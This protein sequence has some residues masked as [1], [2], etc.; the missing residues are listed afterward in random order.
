MFTGRRMDKS[1]TI[2]TCKMEH[3]SA[4]KRKEIVTH[5]LWMNLED[6]MLN[7]ISQSEKGKHYIIPLMWDQ[8]K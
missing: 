2:Y 3:Y 7:D 8:R 1:N 5:T 6:I 4:S